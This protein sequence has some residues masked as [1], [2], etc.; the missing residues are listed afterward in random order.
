MG[1]ISGHW[2]PDILK[3]RGFYSAGLLR[4]IKNNPELF[5]PLWRKDG[6]R[7]Y[8]I[9]HGSGIQGAGIRPGFDPRRELEQTEGPGFGIGRMRGRFV[10]DVDDAHA[11]IL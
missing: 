11:R 2:R 1:G 4:Y 8:R 7:I 10:S 5:V 6:I 3:T 9:R